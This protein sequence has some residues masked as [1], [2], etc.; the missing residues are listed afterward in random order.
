[1]DW[2]IIGGI[3]IKFCRMVES[4]AKTVPSTKNK[5]RTARATAILRKITL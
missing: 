2:D 1:M 5:D 4:T 3:S